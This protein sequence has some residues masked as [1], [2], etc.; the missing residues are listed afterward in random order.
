M[1]ASSQIATARAMQAR[2]V[3]TRPSHAAAIGATRPPKPQPVKTRPYAKPNEAAGTRSATPAGTIAASEP[4][5]VPSPNSAT[6]V[7][8]PPLLSGSA[9]EH[10]ASRTQ[11]RRSVVGAP[12]RSSNGP[13]T[14]RPNRLPN[15]SSATA[16]P[17]SAGEPINGPA[18]A[19]PTS[20]GADARQN[21]SH[22]RATTRQ[23]RAGRPDDGGAG[24]VPGTRK[25]ATAIATASS[26]P[27]ATNVH[28][29]P[30]DSRAA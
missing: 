3:G 18:C 29:R 24:G 20:P 11:D 27:S 19:N 2:N 1:P 12:I 26:T 7:S 6:Y 9:T 23:G 21:T 17:A 8:Q 4:Y 28:R 13:P 14:T 5:W 30:Y 22:H 25:L 16:S 15:D 10:T